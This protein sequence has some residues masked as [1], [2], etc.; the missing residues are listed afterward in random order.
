MRNQRLSFEEF[1]TLFQDHFVSEEQLRKE[2]ESFGAV[3]ERLD[4]APVPE[5]S[6]REKA[7]IFRRSWP[8]P[9]PDRS[10]AWTWPAF[11]RRPA[12]TF[13][14]GLIF[15]CVLM[16]GVLS[17]PPVPPRPAAASQPLTI[18]RTPYMQVYKGKLVQEFYPQIE[19]P[20]IV[21][22][23]PEKASPP[24]RVLYGT[25]DNGEIYVVWNL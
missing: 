21:L 18:E 6:A 11:F 20:R 2:Y 13:A 17:R 10:W 15:G 5:L 19:D 25:L 9:G 4:R 12:V 24:Q 8:G 7:E 16:L 3:F 22:E 14:A 23:R 1:R